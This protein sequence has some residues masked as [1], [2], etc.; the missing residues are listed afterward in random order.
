MNGKH[1]KTILVIVALCSV[2]ALSVFAFIKFSPKTTATNESIAL[3]TQSKIL[4]I[5]TDTD[6]LK[7]WEEQLWKTDPK[8]P[9]SD[10]DGT[11]DG[12]EIK[13]GRDPLKAGPNDKLDSGTVTGKI[14]PEIESDLTETD[15]FS[16]E[17]FAK[18]VSTSQEGKTPTEADFQ[19]FLNT[20]IQKQVDSQKAKTYLPTDFSVDSNE[21]PEKIKA[22]GNAVATVL[23]KKPPQPLEYEMVIVDRA[24]TNN[25]PSEL[26]KLEPLI[27]EY[28]R[29]EKDLLKITVPKSAVENHISLINS[30]NAMGWSLNAF[31]YIL[32]DPIKS[33]PGVSAYPD[34]SINFQGSIRQFKYYFESNG[35]TFINGDSGYKYFDTI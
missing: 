29:I 11:K 26:K 22:Y 34:N 13:T 6:G 7:D 9:D 28:K 3:N 18:V 8:S 31:I 16:R 4:A 15:K 1:V 20:T 5:D 30:T 21:T 14:N 25:D 33:L 27:A 12:D 35:V 2:V 24:D 17:L 19:E 32:T 23:T 10:G